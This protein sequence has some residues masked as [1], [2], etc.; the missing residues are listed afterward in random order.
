MDESVVPTGVHKERRSLIGAAVG[1]AV[2]A[3]AGGVWWRYQAAATQEGATSG[4]PAPEL[5]S[6]WATPWA[7]P[8]GKPL[9]VQHYQGKPLLIN[10]WATWCPPCVEELP[11]LNAFFLQNRVKGWQVLGLAVDR[12]DMVQRFLRQNPIDFPVVMASLGG[13]DLARALG[14]VAGGLPFTVAVN[15]AGAIAQ[16]KLGRV[17]SDN[18]QQWAGLK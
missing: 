7:D 14:N 3:V 6:F 13:A 1:S 5:E 18:L 9:Q 17:T 10:F 2:V 11:L 12:V 8:A 16:R 4:V 15:G